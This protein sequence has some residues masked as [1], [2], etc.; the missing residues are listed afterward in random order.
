MTASVKT[1]AVAAVVVL[2]IPVL[3]GAAAAGVVAS[4]FTS[5]GG[6]DCAPA[7]ASPATGVAGYGPEELAN[8]AT[9]VAV[10]KQMRVPEYGWV[11]A[12]AAAMQESRL[13]N[14]DYGD[15]DSLG[16]FQQRP[17]QGWGT[18]AQILNPSYAAAQFYEHLLA[19]PNWQQMSVTGAAQA[20]QRSAYPNAY[21]Q[22]EHAARQVV[23]A[24]NGV[25]CTAIT[26]PGQLRTSWPSEQATE[27]DPTS[28]GRITP[29]TLALVRALQAGAM[30][31]DGLGCYEARPANPS[32]DHPQ[33]RA[34]D[35]LLEPGDP[36]AVSEGWRITEWLIAHQPV[37]GVRYLIWQGQYWSADNPT[38][39]P[40]QSDAYGC[41]DPANV[42]GCHY[43]HIHVSM[44]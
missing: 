9:I 14:L 4:L 20:V 3:I 10:G 12:V 30:T 5:G 6:A 7:G 37:L 13:R 19:V 22:H 43:D 17:S 28:R 31:G 29:R 26:A 41:P 16:L 18:P 27:P 11:I 34:C 23:G 42:T 38:W 24:L 35:I 15:R 36:Q 39:Q 44:Y 40:Y 2:L 8:A 32:S 25:T 21:A 33:G 1:A